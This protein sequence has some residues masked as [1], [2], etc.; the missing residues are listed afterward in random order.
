M[1][2]GSPRSLHESRS[3]S[4]ITAICPPSLLSV[5]Q[6]LLSGP[7]APVKFRVS[8]RKE[9]D[10]TEHWVPAV[11]LPQAMQ[12]PQWSKGQWAGGGFRA[13]GDLHSLLPSLSGDQSL[14]TWV[15]A[16]N[17][18]WKSQI[19]WEFRCSDP[20]HVV[21]L[22]KGKYTQRESRW[23]SLESHMSWRSRISLNIFQRKDAGLG[24][25]QFRVKTEP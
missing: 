19:G 18:S 22:R 4:I 14:Y 23:W 15:L 11:C 7:E 20:W 24:G 13:R 6:S 17:R 10:K 5:R 16:D 25:R 2:S 12:R 1:S 8:G 3:T 9:G 21:P